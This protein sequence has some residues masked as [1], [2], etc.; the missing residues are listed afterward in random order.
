MRE[1][2]AVT[3]YLYIDGGFLAWL[4]KKAEEAY[5]IELS[6]L[7]L[8][9]FDISHPFQQTFYYDAWPSR[10]NE[11]EDEHKAIVAQ[12][13]KLF[14]FINRTPFVHTREG[15]TRSRSPTKRTPLEQKGVDILLGHRCFQA[16]HSQKHDP[17]A[18]HDDGPQLFPAFR[19]PTRYA[20]IRAS[21]LLH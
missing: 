17:S 16:G 19:S 18:H 21:A 3:S 4:I 12:K 1:E 5:G 13:Q 6:P 20:R 7:A 10:K 11:T 15:I 9:Y 14:N 2:I 8:N